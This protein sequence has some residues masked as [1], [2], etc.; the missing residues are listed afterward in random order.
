MPKKMGRFVICLLALVLAAGC[1]GQPGG[2]GA[3][4]SGGQEKLE[5]GRWEDAQK[6]WTIEAYES[7]LSEYPGG[8]HELEARDLL[9]ELWDRKLK[10]MPPQELA[11]LTAVIESDQ[12]VIKFKF[13]PAEAPNTVRN[14]IKLAQTHFYDGLI[15]HRV[16]AGYLIQTGC[17]R[18]DGQ[19]GP[20]YTIK[21]EFNNRPH[22]EGALAMARSLNPDSAGSQFYISLTPQPRLDHYYTVFGQVS[23]GLA[24]VQA[25]GKLP[26]DPK[27]RP[28]NPPV[29][30]KVYVEGFAASGP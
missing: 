16:I 29:M 7:Y 18:G 28:L 30:N 10:A 24:V 13:F 15:F 11:R 4:D 12:G 17:P 22:L 1:K 2:P 26:T 8:P 27:D 9:R 6:A 21:A 14:F 20:G 25:I 5:A 3:G 19:G 23:E